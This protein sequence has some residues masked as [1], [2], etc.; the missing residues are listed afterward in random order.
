MAY[1]ILSFVA[2][3]FN[4]AIGSLAHSLNFFAELDYSQSRE[5]LIG[6][7]LVVVLIG[8][9]CW[10]LRRPTKFQ[11]TRL[12]TGAIAAVLA[13]AVVDFIAGQGMR[14]HYNRAASADTPFTSALEQSGLVPANGNI[15]RNV[16][17]VMVESLGVPVGNPEMQQLLFAQYQNA[18]LQS[19]FEITSGETVFYNSTTAG[20]IRELCG[21]WGDYF[22]LVDTKDSSCLPARLAANGVQTWAYHS[23]VGDFF[24]RSQWYPNIGFTNMVFRDD[25]VRGG[26]NLCGG[27]FPGACDRDVPSQIAAQLKSGEAPQLVYWLTV[28]SHLPVP[29]GNNLDVEECER[30]SPKLAAEYPM[31][32]RQFAIWDSID[33]ALVREITAADFPPTDILIVGDHM[34]PYYDRYN[35]QQFAPD[36]VPWLALKWRSK[37]S[38]QPQDGSLPLIAAAKP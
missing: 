38:D 18:D 29:L 9:A 20:E 12:L 10:L 22:D 8:T 31:I 24:E 4:L 2:G 17:I 36:R 16:L 1:S 28:N 21:R 5:Y 30:I 26:S 33:S 25:L 13:L 34:P 11:D 35:R 3:L 23:F 7:A 15:D 37:V 19:Q 32:C 27:V 6:T 14:G